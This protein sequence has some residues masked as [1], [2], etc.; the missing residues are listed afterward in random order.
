[1]TMILRARTNLRASIAKLALSAGLLLASGCGRSEPSGA[2]RKPGAST[3]PT[4][5]DESSAA[6]CK[7][8]ETGLAGLAARVSEAGEVLKA[9]AGSSDADAPEVALALVA[10]GPKLVTDVEF[11]PGKP[12][13]FV[14]TGQSGE[15]AL[16]EL[17]EEPGKLARKLGTLLSLQVDSQGEMGLLSVAFHPQYET[18]GRLFVHYNPE[19]KMATRV[20][21]FA[22]PFAQLGK[23]AALEKKVLLELKQPFKNHNGGELA[24]GPDGKL[25]LGLGDGGSGNDPYDNGQKL[26]TLLGKILRLDVDGESLVPSDNPFVG[27]SDARPEI[28]ALGLRNPWKISFDPKGRLVVADVGQNRFEEIDLVSK[29]D[30]LGWNTREAAHCFD[31][32]TDCAT[33]GLV[34]PVF[35]YTREQGQS[36]SGGHV[37]TGTGIPALRGRYVLADFVTR[38]FWALELPDDARARAKASVLG[39]FETGPAAFGRDAQGELYASDFGSGKIYKLIAP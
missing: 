14:V 30:N 37:Y 39:V 17:A 9:S 24:F 29:G 33:S 19:G 21:E 5:A 6:C 18:N 11:V 10:E 27:R 32:K 22:L 20:S 23:T 35:E 2:A 38:R 12:R 15:A 31:P 16:L 25:Y 3:M 8:P 36:V 4:I 13:Q 7:K 26:S 1:M 34:D 28:F